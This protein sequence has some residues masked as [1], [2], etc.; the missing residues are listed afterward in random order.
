MPGLDMDLD[1]PSFTDHEVL[2]DARVM[3]GHG[4][5]FPSFSFSF[6]FFLP[7]FLHLFLK[8]YNRGE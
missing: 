7:F 8:S 5:F 3:E 1:E 6:P 4:F 2:D